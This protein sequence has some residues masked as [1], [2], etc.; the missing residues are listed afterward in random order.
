MGLEFDFYL[1]C[2]GEGEGNILRE[3][4]APL[5]LCS[6]PQP[7]TD[8]LIPFSKCLALSKLVS[9]LTGSAPILVGSEGTGLFD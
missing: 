9:W 3:A 7:G 5:Y 6:P 4:S 2:W 8:I 1:L